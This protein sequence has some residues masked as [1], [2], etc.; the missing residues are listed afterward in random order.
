M[1][2]YIETHSYQGYG[3][4][5]S[6]KRTKV[7]D[8]YERKERT[9]KLEGSAHSNDTKVSILDD[10]DYFYFIREM[11][12]KVEKRIYIVMFLMH[13]EEKEEGSTLEL[14]KELV[15]KKKNGVE[16]KVILDRADEK[17]EY[18]ANIVNKNAFDFLVK[19]GIPVLPDKGDSKTHTKLML[20]DDEHVIIGNHNW[21]SG[22]F[23]RYDDKSVYVCSK[24]LSQTFSQY[25]DDLWGEY[26]KTEEW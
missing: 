19:N 20:I 15:E 17:D 25:F 3:K 11:L 13:F 18:G 16:V 4:Y 12:P 24:E 10:S 14:L 6:T 8:W 23:F 22:S 7:K 1:G 5:G 2:N 21:T 9:R 26:N